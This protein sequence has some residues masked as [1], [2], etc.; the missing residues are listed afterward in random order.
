M[1]NV[2]RLKTAFGDRITFWGGVDTMRV[3]PG[4]T[5]EE[6]RAEVDR[7]VE[8]LGRDGGYVLCPVHNVQPDVPVENLL[9][10]YERGRRGR[11][12]PV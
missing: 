8:V 11:E 7:R 10:L 5:P 4:G 12:V 1:R 6:V 3:M 2:E 9:A